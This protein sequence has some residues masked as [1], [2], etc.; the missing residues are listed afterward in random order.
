MQALEFDPALVKRL[1]GAD[2]EALT[3]RLPDEERRIIRALRDAWYTA[4][5][6]R[7]RLYMFCYYSKAMTMQ[8]IA[9]AYGV[10]KA[11]VSRTL[12]RAR[13]RLRGVL[14]YYL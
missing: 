9:Q 13:G 4:L 3:E 6:P 11:T 7:Q 1:A 10:N 5:T 2:A 12:R 8:R 14:H